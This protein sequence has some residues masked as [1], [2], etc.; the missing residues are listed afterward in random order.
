MGA[1]VWG[2]LWQRGVIK[3]RYQGERGLCFPKH[4]GSSTVEVAWSLLGAWGCWSKQAPG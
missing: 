2:V 1:R 3:A 4:P